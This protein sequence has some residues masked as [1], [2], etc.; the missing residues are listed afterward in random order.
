MTD[1]T[2]LEL[3]S[4]GHS[5]SAIAAASG[6]LSEDHVR[7]VIVGKWHRDKSESGDAR[8]TV[9]P[10]NGRKA[11]LPPETVRRIRKAM[12]RMRVAD[13]A[14]AYGVSKTTVMRIWRGESYK[15]V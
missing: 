5:C 14:R 2:I 10:K 3:F 7:G 6:I 15:E 13:T 12:G 9:S 11:A 1:E 8:M 4:Q